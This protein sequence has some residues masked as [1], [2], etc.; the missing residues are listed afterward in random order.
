MRRMKSS[1][2]GLYKGGLWIEE[3]RAVKEGTKELFFDKF[4]EKG[5][6][7]LTLDDVPFSNITNQDNSMFICQ[8]EEEDV[9]NV[10]WEECY[11]GV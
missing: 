8:F 11:M 7:R 6:T 3:L 10:V 2:K 1:I 9:R 4:I 5:G